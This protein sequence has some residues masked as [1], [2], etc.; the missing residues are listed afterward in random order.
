VTEDWRSTTNNQLW[1]GE[2]SINNPC[3]RGYRIPNITELDAERNSWSQNSSVDAYNSALKLQVSGCRD[4]AAGSISD[5]GSGGY[6]WSSTVNSNYPLYL[7]FSGFAFTDI[8]NRVVGRSVRCIKDYPASIG[9]ID[10][11]GSLNQG[12]L[13]SG[14]LSNNVSITINYKN[15]N[16][17]LYDAQTIQSTGVTGL[18]A[19]LSAGNLNN[20]D[21]SLQFTISGTPNT[22]GTAYF[23]LTLGGKNIVFS[24][25][26]NTLTIGS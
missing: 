2:N 19:T 24:R 16:G 12:I 26:V 3:P 15:G 4:Y 20:G 9:S 1:Q 23:S 11:I 13:Y 5:V 21:G 22:T 6:Y 7:Y 18:T 8:A 17:V 25:T 10:T 14:I